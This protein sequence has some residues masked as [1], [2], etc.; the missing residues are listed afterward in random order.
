MIRGTHAPIGFPSMRHELREKAKEEEK[1]NDERREEAREKRVK[2]KTGSRFVN[3]RYA[4][5]NRTLRLPG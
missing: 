1:T 3:N 2:K 5:L 4:S